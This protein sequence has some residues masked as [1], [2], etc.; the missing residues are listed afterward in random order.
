MGKGGEGWGWGWAGAEAG[1]RCSVLSEVLGVWLA[2]WDLDLG[3]SR[4]LA[5]QAQVPG[6]CISG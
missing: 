6:A 2:G 1:S 3:T 5:A 4:E